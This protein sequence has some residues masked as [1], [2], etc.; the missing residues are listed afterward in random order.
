MIKKI[1]ENCNFSQK[2][3]KFMNFC[4]VNA[5]LLKISELIEA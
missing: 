4:L 2:K 3:I 5:D 1:N